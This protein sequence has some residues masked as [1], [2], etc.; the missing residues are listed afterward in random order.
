M[1]PKLANHAVILVAILVL[2]LILINVYLAVGLKLYTTRIVLII[3][4]ISSIKIQS[5]M[6]V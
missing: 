6:F 3:V 2:L 1:L 5:I 4:Q